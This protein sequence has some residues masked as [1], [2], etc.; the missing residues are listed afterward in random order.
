MQELRGQVAIVT[1]ASRGIGFGVARAL[2]L[3]GMRLAVCARTEPD[4]ERAGLALAALGT[5]VLARPCDVSK[6]LDV[7]GLVAE[8]VER[9][10]RVDVLV[11]NAGVGRFG[12][13]EDSREEDL[14]AV[15]AVNL[16]GVF[17]FARAVFPIFKAQRRGYAIT[18]SSYAGKE[19]LRNAGAY[20]ASKFGAIGLTESLLK[21]GVA[22][23]IRA[24]SICPGMVDTELVAGAGVPPEDMLRVEDVAE[25]CLFLLRLSDVA[26]VR[27]VVLQRVGAID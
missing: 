10:G 21:E 26:V 13:I 27:E 4:I 7:E 1:G 16:K 18:V 8:T 20:G 2:A 17:F 14:D 22:Y 5:E 12:A 25:T 19:G 6:A 11:C 24:T 15:L 23:G 9:F 3:A